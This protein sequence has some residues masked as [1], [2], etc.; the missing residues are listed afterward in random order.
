[1]RTDR[2]FE[3]MDY[4]SL[5]NRSGLQIPTSRSKNGANPEEPGIMLRGG[6]AGNLRVVG[7]WLHGMKI[8]EVANLAAKGD[9]EAMTGI[10]ILK[11]AASKAQKY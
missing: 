4:K 6:K 11:Q 8:G 7:E 10:K 5:L 2:L 1:M 3:I 9:K